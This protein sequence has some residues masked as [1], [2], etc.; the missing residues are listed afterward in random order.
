MRLVADDD[1]FAKIKKQILSKKKKQFYD[2]HV[3][4]DTLTCHGG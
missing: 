3:L 1:F 4:L 2:L